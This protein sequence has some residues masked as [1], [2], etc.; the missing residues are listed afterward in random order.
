MEFEIISLSFWVQIQDSLQVDAFGGGAVLGVICFFWFDTS[1]SFCN[2]GYSFSEKL[3]SH[4]STMKK[5]TFV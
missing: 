1:A 5:A 3:R 2:I 4:Y